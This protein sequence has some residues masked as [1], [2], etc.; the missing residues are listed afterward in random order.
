MDG[1]FRI[2]C[3][4]WIYAER[5]V[6]ALKEH[7]LFELISKFFAYLRSS[8]LCRRT[9]F[10]PKT[11]TG[12]HS[13]RLLW[14][15]YTLTDTELILRTWGIR[16]IDLQTLRTWGRITPPEIDPGRGI[17][18][19]LECVEGAVLRYLHHMKGSVHFVMLL[20]E[21]TGLDLITPFLGTGRPSPL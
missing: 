15:R 19:H 2:G 21:A 12:Q 5:G 9:S 4:V 7:N 11:R 20:G 8:S 14:I 3:D 18:F 6:Q 13:I 16:R 17:R 1:L 10:C